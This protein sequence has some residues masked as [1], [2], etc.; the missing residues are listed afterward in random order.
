MADTTV[1]KF[2]IRFSL[3][4][5]QAQTAL[6]NIQK[7]FQKIQKQAKGTDRIFS[8]LFGFAS[9]AGLAKITKDSAK[10][11]HSMTI[12]AQKTGISSQKL[13]S[14]QSAFNSI[15]AS[16]EKALKTV[17]RITEGLARTFIAGG[18]SQML[19]ILA[20]MGIEGFDEQG[21][22][23]DAIEIMGDIADWI[24]NNPAGLSDLE[25]RQYL[26]DNL[27]L[28][29]EEY[30]QMKGGKSAYLSWIEQQGKKTESLEEKH[31]KSLESLNR[32]IS[33]C[34]EL[35]KNKFMKAVADIAPVLEKIIN[36]VTDLISKN[37]EI[38]AVITA[39]TML[40]LAFKGLALVLS[41]FLLKLGLITAAFVGA[42]KAGEAI[43]ELIANIVIA[44]QELLKS[45]LDWIVDKFK[46]V[47]AGIAEWWDNV[48]DILPFV[49]S[50]A[51]KEENKRKM[52]KETTQRKLE[53][54]IELYE[55]D[56]TEENW[57]KYITWGVKYA[58][59]LPN[60]EGFP[61]LENFLGN[62]GA[63]G[64]AR[65]LFYDTELT[66]ASNPQISGGNTTNINSTTT[67]YVNEATV[68]REFVEENR[69][70]A[71]NMASAAEV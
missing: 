50:K 11:A 70:M 63:R 18:N 2:V 1:K 47:M 41:P 8:K 60:D 26:A 65:D 3:V 36:F 54:L 49:D 9:I 29:P 35:I 58:K 10:L 19:S 23:R 67:M 37:P 68:D 17:E 33:E 71:L 48:K 52:A 56:P 24:K 32:T 55:K 16:G 30:Q 14:M 7:N 57:E 66:K 62:M 13:T 12:I 34:A 6:S 61:L 4:G 5:K 20:Q 28:S 45:F 25:M 21:R 15:G 31:I 22:Q 51:E 64:I 42:Y 40:G 43:G 27:G 39:V 38:S 46:S 53:T 59:Q 44:I 69:G